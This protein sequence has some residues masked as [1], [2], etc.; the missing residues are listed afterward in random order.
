MVSV[1]PPAA[2]SGAVR[3]YLVCDARDLEAVEPLRQYLKQQGCKATLP[4]FEGDE[5]ELREDH[6]D[7]LRLCDA[8][9][10]YY[11]Q[12][13][14]AWQRK[15]MRE[16]VGSMGL[17]RKAPLSAVGIVLGAPMT[18]AKEDFS[19]DDAIVMKMP[20]AFAPDILREF[21]TQIQAAR[22]QEVV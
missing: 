4:L 3:I 19:S 5:A 21:L 20:E 15:K 2:V 13:S 11:G 9:L 17:G 10:I 16:V 7:N 1:P 18:D 6:E 22:K 12:G 14:E 8:V